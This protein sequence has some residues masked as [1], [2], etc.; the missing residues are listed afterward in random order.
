[1]KLCGRRQSFFFFFFKSQFLPALRVTGGA[2]D[3]PSYLGTEAG[4]HPGQV[5]SSS[6]GHTETNSYLHS[7]LQVPTL[8][9]VHVIELCEE[10]GEPGRNPRTHRTSWGTWESNLEPSCFEITVLTTELQ[11]TAHLNHTRHDHKLQY[12]CPSISDFLAK[13]NYLFVLVLDASNKALRNSFRI[14]DP[15]MSR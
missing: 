13:S 10:A 1:M 14:A 3:Y 8:P 2:K 6:Q 7:N 9:H 4:L 5:S 11:C 15:D 12:N